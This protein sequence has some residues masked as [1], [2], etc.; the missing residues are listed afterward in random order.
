M[1]WGERQQDNVV[2]HVRRAAEPKDMGMERRDCLFA[3]NDDSICT[4]DTLHVHNNTQTRTYHARAHR[5]AHAAAHMRTHPHA[6]ARTCDQNL[7]MTHSPN[8]GAA[9]L[10]VS[11]SENR[12][13]IQGPYCLVLKVSTFK[14]AKRNCTQKCHTHAGN[15]EDVH[16]GTCESCTGKGWGKCTVP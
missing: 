2:P 6:C 13:G 14:P 16:T 3:G 4:S 11:I 1:L 10:F 5:H 7:G 9:A 8:L 15:P 12:L